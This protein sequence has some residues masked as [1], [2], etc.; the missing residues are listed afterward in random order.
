MLPFGGAK[1]SG[2]ALFVEVLASVVSGAALST[3]VRSMF[4]DFSGPA[5]M[6][7]AFVVID[8]ARLSGRSAYDQ[9]VEELFRRMGDAAAGERP[10]RLPGDVRW[11]ALHESGAHGVELD[12]GTCERMRAIAGRHSVA[13]P[14]PSTLR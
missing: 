6:G 10:L 2:V 14:S 13:M 1:G 4:N 11:Q 9:R 12:T 3:D 7:H 8:V 5:G